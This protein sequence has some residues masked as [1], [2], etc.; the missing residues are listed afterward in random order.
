M[1]SL[2]QHVQGDHDIDDAAKRRREPKSVVGESARIQADHELHVAQVLSQVIEIH[3]EIGAAALLARLDEDNAAAVGDVV[4]FHRLDREQ[5][6]E[7]GVAVVR[8]SSGVQPVAATCRRE[9]T[10]ALGPGAQ[11]R[12]LVEVAVQDGR[13]RRGA[14]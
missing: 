14:R 10:E 6:R 8:D 12:L 3:L 1:E 7:G 11:G 2:G 5:C 4:R 13:A 9:G